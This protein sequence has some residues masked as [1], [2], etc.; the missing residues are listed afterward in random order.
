MTRA[1]F[2]T[3]VLNDV[4]ELRVT[5]RVIAGTMAL[6]LKRT[7]KLCPGLTDLGDD[8]DPADGQVEDSGSSDAPPPSS[9]DEEPN[10]I[11][12]AVPIHEPDNPSWSSCEYSLTLSILSIERD[13]IFPW[14]INVAVDRMLDFQEYRI[15]KI[16]LT[17]R[18][19]SLDE[20]LAEGTSEG[21]PYSSYGSHR[22]SVEVKI[23]SVSTSSSSEGETSSLERAMLKKRGH[24]REE[25]VQE[26]MGEEMVFPGASARSDIQDG[27]STHF[28]NSKVMASLKRPTAE[29]KYLLPAR[30]RFVLP[31]VDGTI[32]TPPAKCIAAYRAAFSYGL[33]FPLHLV[34]MD[35]LN[36]Y[37]LATA[38]ITPTS[39]HNI[40]SVIA[41]CEL[42][43]LTCTGRASRRSTQ[44]KGLP[45]RLGALGGIASTIRKPS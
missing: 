2:Y 7:R 12:Y 45:V 42:H 28:P 15:D 14:E 44:F 40:C 24:A 13:V 29:D 23:K 35:I 8:P 20:L 10:K 17:G 3:M 16:R 26:F 18:L 36:K 41:M 6:V 4:V 22:S 43:R 30:Y 25:M 11:P 21:N 37:E 34:M 32:N 19:R 9:D 39:W 27:P 38:Q 31:E 1:I 33:R 5:S